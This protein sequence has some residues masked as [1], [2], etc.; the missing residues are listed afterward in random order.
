MKVMTEPKEAMK[1]ELEKRLEER[2]AR[3]AAA[4]AEA[5]ATADTLTDDL[6]A[7]NEELEAIARERDGL[8]DQL[9]RMRAEFDNFRKRTAREAEQA[10]RMAA[11]ALIRDLLPVVDHLDLALQHAEDESGGLAQGVQMVRDQFVDA[12]VRHG[13]EPIEALDQ[14]FDP[15][16][17]EALLQREDDSVPAHTVLEEFQKGYLLGGRILRPSKVVVSTGGPEPPPRQSVEEAEPGLED[18]DGDTVEVR[19]E[20]DD[21]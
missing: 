16:V 12:L 18:T 5:A 7:T 19:I 20:E 6:A 10:R 21:R 9:L 13:L 17:H 8:R 15:N 11:E 14:P 3:E 2:A 1:S 4:A